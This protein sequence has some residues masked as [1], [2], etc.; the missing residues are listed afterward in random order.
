MGTN[1]SFPVRCS[2]RTAQAYA[3]EKRDIQRMPWLYKQ[4]MVS[5]FLSMSISRFYF[6]A[7]I[8]IC[9]VACGPSEQTKTELVESKRIECVNRFCSG[10]VL[11]V[12]RPGEVA[13]KLN[14]LWFVGPSKYFS[15][16]GNTASFEW[17]DHRP[18]D[19]ATPR[20]VDAQAAANNGDGYDFSV[21]IFLSSDDSPGP[22]SG[23]KLLE[24]ARENGWVSSQKTQRPGL[25]V[26]QMSHVRGPDGRFMDLATY[27]VATE[28]RGLDGTSPVAVCFQD[29]L[30]GNASASF[31]WR[32]GIR[33]ALRMNTKHC[34]DWPEIY[35]EAIRV[36]ELLK[37][38]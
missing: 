21:A 28:Q 19:P 12:I 27:F 3:S 20:P 30:S 31:V 24:I 4:P 9:L 34:A 23:Q 14:G 15:S 22:S 25:D 36:L 5:D 16:A 38:E 35:R 18:L 37:K 33:A 13:I 29:R 17:W 32:P 26:V 8:S 6:L 1:E 10:D 11:P 2:V 7:L